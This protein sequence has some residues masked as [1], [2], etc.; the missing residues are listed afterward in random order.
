MSVIFPART[1]IECS[2]FS[3]KKTRVAKASQSLISPP[4]LITF[5]NDV[6]ELIRHKYNLYFDIKKHFYRFCLF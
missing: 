4:F 1:R 6:N 5:P 3:F 2:T